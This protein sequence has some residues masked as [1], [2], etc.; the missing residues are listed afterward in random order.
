MA[1]HV[2]AGK[3]AQPH[4]VPWA[5]F[6]LRLTLGGILITHGTLR[7][8]P[9]FAEK[10]APAKVAAMQA[11]VEKTAGAVGVTEGIMDT[12]AARV[13]VGCAELFVGVLVVLGLFMRMALVPVAIFFVYEMVQQVRAGE[14][15]VW[16]AGSRAEQFLV[17][18]CLTGILMVLGPGRC[19]CQRR[20]TE[21]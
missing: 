14:P 8:V 12:K 15:I 2:D 17:L 7:L 11:P 9:S 10:V 16:Y 19:S 4:L 3:A 18:L 6:L 13:L 1:Q 21:S 20:L 5:L